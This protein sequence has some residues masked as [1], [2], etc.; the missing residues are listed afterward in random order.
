VDA[1]DLAFARDNSTNFLTA[2]KLISIPAGDR[3][4]PGFRLLLR[5]HCDAAIAVCPLM[6]G[7]RLI[8]RLR[9]GTPDGNQTYTSTGI[10]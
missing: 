7:V 4:D 6:L 2:L 10:T 1:S 8:Q 5:V 3:R 9:P